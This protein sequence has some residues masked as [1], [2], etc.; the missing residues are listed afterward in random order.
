MT[1]GE[2]IR[3]MSSDE[4]ATLLSS[5]S[6]TTCCYQYDVCCQSAECIEGHKQW[7]KNKTNKEMVAL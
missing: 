2:R 5:D 4:L 1:N 3:M 7:L 6:C